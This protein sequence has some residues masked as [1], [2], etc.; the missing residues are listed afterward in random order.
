[1][2]NKYKFLNA[3]KKQSNLTKTENLAV[4]HKST[5]SKV[6][7]FF[8]LGGALR[9]RADKEVID[10]FMGA[11]HE[12]RLLALK[13]LFYIR[14]I[15]EGQGE[16]KVFR[17]ILKHLAGWYNHILGTN[18]ANIPEFGRWDDML[19]LIGID[20]DHLDK[21]IKNILE[22]Q[23]D[24]DTLLDDDTSLLAKWM[25]SVNAG[26]KS[27]Q[28]AKKLIKLLDFKTEKEYRKLLSHIRA[29]LNILETKMCKK[30][31]STINY[32]H[33]PSKA[34][35]I[36]SRKGKAFRRHDEERFEQYLEDVESGKKTIK[37]KVTYPY[38]ILREARN[39]P[40][41]KTLD[42]LWANLPN[43]C[44]EGEENSIVVC[45]VSG[46]MTGM[47]S[48]N[49]GYKRTVEPILISTS[50]AIY[51]AERNKGVFHNHFITFSAEPNLVEVKG[52]T[53]YEKYYKLSTSGGWGMNTDLNAV[54]RLILDTAYKN[55]ISDE[56]MIKKIYIV[57]DMEFDDCGSLT[58][59]QK[60]R[61][62]YLSHGYTIPQIVF[63]MVESRHN[64]LPITTE[65]KNV[66]MVSGASP[67][68]FKNMMQMKATSAYDLM[69][70]ILNSPRYESIIL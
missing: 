40:L 2:Q 26:T 5:T 29:K 51:F 44:L 59:Y 13:T 35:L 54:F 42:I 60:I 16:R 28:L 18:L 45:D 65:D 6:L 20:P 58:N 30:Q 62:M 9:T 8:S 4:T 12:D 39:N 23:L 36:H 55:K 46:S 69:L 3:L 31:W 34:M 57:S 50:L 19:I 17:T 64:Q 33:V 15:R 1:M 43:Y 32:E 47:Y 27:R 67:T 63:W 61:S 11:F 41:D 7:D 56:E 53:L 68:I 24:Y 70:E 25:P 49:E 38:E 66:F 48:W 14:D 22:R 21:K 52:E 10:L 37:V